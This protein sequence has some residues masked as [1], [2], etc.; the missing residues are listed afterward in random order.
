MKIKTKLVLI[1]A[2]LAVS[3][4]FSSLVSYFQF[5]NL[6]VHVSEDISK[7]MEE[8]INLIDFHLL[9]EHM[10]FYDVLLTQAAREYAFTGDR[11]WLQKYLVTEPELDIAINRMIQETSGLAK[12]SFEIINIANLKLVEM[13]HM[14]IEQVN[15]G[16]RTEAIRILDSKEYLDQK[17]SF[18]DGFRKYFNLENLGYESANHVST[19]ELKTANKKAGELIERNVYLS[20]LSFFM[21]LLLSIAIIYIVSKSVVRP[22][23]KFIFV[24]QELKR[25]N[26][27][28]RVDMQTN[29]EFNELASTLNKSI[30]SL[31]KIDEEH[32]QIEKAKTEF[33]SITGHELRSPM[34]PMLAHLQMLNTGYFGKLNKQQ[35]ASIDIVLRNTTRLDDL[36]KDFLEISRI[37]VGRLNFD[38]V[39]TNLNEHIH[40]LVK[41]MNAYLPEKKIIIKSFIGSLPA[42]YVDPNR[43]MQVLR[44]LLNNAKKFSHF[45]GEIILMVNRR[46]N[47]IEFSVKDSGIGIPE[48]KKKLVFNPFYIGEENIYREHGGLGLGLPICK[49]IVESQNGKIWFESKSGKGSTFYF[50]IPLTPVREPKLIKDVFKSKNNH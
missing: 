41:E 8:S 39:R 26:F 25:G 42:M 13:E 35:K 24:A 2:L 6:K 28:A 17:I 34:T 43:T 27:K 19:V 50:T 31:D 20:S 7:N 48:N 38:F 44:N 4:I 29:D 12:E 45:N 9:S 22:L 30:E 36:I 21:L 18:K 14:A 33:L 23:A 49:G 3:V 16:N 11:L 46:G 15:V 32:K 5:N 10:Q 1:F 47:F 37:E 40:R